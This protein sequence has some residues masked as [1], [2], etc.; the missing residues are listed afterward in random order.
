MHFVFH[1][2]A[3]LAMSAAVPSAAIA[4]APNSVLI[5]EQR[6][7]MA[8]LSFLDGEWAGPA[9]AQERTGLLRMTQTER[10]GTLLD[11]TVRLVEGR[12]Y[13]AQGKTIFNAFA[14]ISYDTRAKAYVIT[15]HASGYVTTSNL[16][17]TGNGFEWSVPAGPKARMHFVAVVQNG[18]WHETGDFIGADGK[19]RRNFEMTVKKLR[20][21]AW[22]ATKAVRFR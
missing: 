20:P 16:K 19:A 5:D 22:P 13:D 12:S 7:A 17:L 8:A 18:S 9:Q 1:R 11:G 14:V 4:Q 21:T 3:A 6:K 10:S 15:S 2:V